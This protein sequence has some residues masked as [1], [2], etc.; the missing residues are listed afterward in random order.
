MLENGCKWRDLSM[1]TVR[2]LTHNPHAYELMV[3]ERCAGR[4]SA[5][6]SVAVVSGG[7]SVG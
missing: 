3:K 4:D 6:G 5:S 2:L 1:S 7:W